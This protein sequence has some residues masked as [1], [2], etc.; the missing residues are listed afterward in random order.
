MPYAKP[1]DPKKPFGTCVGD[2]RFGFTQEGRYFDQHKRPVDEN[3]NLMDVD[4]VKATPPVAPV[5]ADED[6]V[7]EENPVDLK[8]WAAGKTVLPWGTVIAAIHQQLGES[9]K[10]KVDAIALINARMADPDDDFT[11]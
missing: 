5:I 8:A 4:P 3:G 10:S 11:A 7:E 2:A 1:F 9:V 6:E